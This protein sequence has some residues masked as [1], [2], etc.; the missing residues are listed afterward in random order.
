MK[1]IIAKN[2]I[3][4]KTEINNYRPSASLFITVVPFITF[5]LS[6]FQKHT[7]VLTFFR[8]CNVV[9]LFPSHFR[10]QSAMET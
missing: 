10:R 1:F 2:E 3:N 9:F 8:E 5:S 7:I 4:I 6:Q